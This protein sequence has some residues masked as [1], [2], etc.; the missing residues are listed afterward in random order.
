MQVSLFH[1]RFP[2][3]MIRVMVNIVVFARS[4][5]LSLVV[6]GVDG[7]GET[8]FFSPFLRFQ[9]CVDAMVNKDRNVHASP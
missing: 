5:S 1:P 6:F 8:V 3:I 2:A 7:G 4:S 9:R